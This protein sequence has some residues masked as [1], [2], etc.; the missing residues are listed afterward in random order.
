LA[1]GAPQSESI[2]TSTF[3]R[4]IER[5][6]QGLRAATA[7][8][9]LSNLTVECLTACEQ[10]QRQAHAHF[11][12]RETELIDLIEL[13]RS[14]V[15]T[16]SRGSLGYEQ[17][18]EASTERL[19]RSARLGDLAMLKRAVQEEVASIKR[20]THE[21]HDMEAAAFRRLTDRVEEL[22]G[23]LGEA[24][25]EESADP[26]T[27]IPNRGAFDRALRRRLPEAMAGRTLVLAVLG[28]DDFSQ[29]NDM[30]GRMVGD[31]ILLC[32]SQLLTN[33]LRPDDR[34]TRFTGEKFAV[35]MA[36]ISLD[37]AK[38]RLAM[39]RQRLAPSYDYEVEGKPVQVS[40]TYSCGITEYADG[41][42]VDTLLRRAV[43]ALGEAQR[44]GRDRT[45]TRRTSFLRGLL[46]RS[47]GQRA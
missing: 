7:S 35:V 46:R 34:V 30:H 28:L 45:V 36:D 18:I 6:R 1:S 43:D 32:V 15:A 23:Q 37:Q 25:D 24:Q 17:Q 16:V 2:D 19:A 31:R 3:R 47:M 42:S 33:G 40:F 5:F 27:G 39:A 22:E 29:L 20:T 21:R 14:A 11:A 8:G 13:L 38:A 26:L 4:S 12:D 10:F 44:R 41:D 9:S